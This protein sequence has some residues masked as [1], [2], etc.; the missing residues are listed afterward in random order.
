MLV[1]LP[2]SPESS[3]L[4]GLIMLVLLLI[5]GAGVSG[6][7]VLLLRDG[8]RTISYLSLRRRVPHSEVKKASLQPVKGRIVTWTGLK[9]F[10]KLQRISSI[11]A[12]WT[13]MGYIGANIRECATLLLPLSETLGGLTT[14]VFLKA[15]LT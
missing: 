11:C 10:E 8:E 5:D 2:S 6:L 12:L 13:R 15:S 9:K 4:A 14:A 3:S 7:N 1:D